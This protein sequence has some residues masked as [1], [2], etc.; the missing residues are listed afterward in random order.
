MLNQNFKCRFLFCAC[1]SASPAAYLPAKKFTMN[2]CVS[3]AGGRGFIMTFTTFMMTKVM[4]R[5]AKPE[6]ERLQ[7][8]EKCMIFL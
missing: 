2:L 6:V 8:R 5:S 3:S 4:K 7:R 1:A